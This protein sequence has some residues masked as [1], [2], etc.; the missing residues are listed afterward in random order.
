MIVCF[1]PA[2]VRAV[3]GNRVTKRNFFKHKR[4]Q[5]TLYMLCLTYKASYKLFFETDGN[6]AQKKLPILKLTS[7][8]CWMEQAD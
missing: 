5:A 7:E 4:Y 6:T 3:R 8:Q 2:V 1:D